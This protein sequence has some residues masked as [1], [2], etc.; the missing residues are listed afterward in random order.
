M[1]QLADLR[2]K[3]IGIEM[4]H[5]DGI[6]INRPHGS[7]DCVF[8]HFL[9]PVNILVQG[10]MQYGRP[11]S[12]IIYVP[13]E[14]QWY[15][16]EG[17]GEFANNW[18]HFDGKMAMHILMALDLPLNTLFIPRHNMFILP[19]LRQMNQE[20]LRKEEHWAEAT[21]LHLQNFLINLSRET[22]A[23]HSIGATAR[24][25]ELGELMH[26]LRAVI[27]DEYAKDWDVTAMA[28]RV[29]LSPS[30]L[31]VLY[32]KFY[33]ISP[34]ADLTQI[35][36]SW[37]KYLLSMTGMSVTEVADSCGFQSVYYFCRLFKKHVGHT[38]G[39]HQRH[40]AVNQKK[41]EQGANM[42]AMS[43]IDHD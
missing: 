8:I 33:G 17:P 43:S 5:R 26:Q 42:Q 12:C 32:R 41:P 18:F 2:V 40:G 23:A 15:E 22:R 9:T 24:M 31:S 20:M 34:M 13:P 35:R 28:K 29:H 19:L 14:P 10:V 30:R 1:L 27:Q 7:G 21:A 11:G 36:L 39:T 25:A 3:S 6:Y 4:R 16:H 38:P 37:A